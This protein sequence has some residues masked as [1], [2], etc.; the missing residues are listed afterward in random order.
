MKAYSVGATGRSPLQVFSDLGCFKNI[1]CLSAER[2]VLVHK[3]ISNLGFSDIGC[4]A[5]IRCLTVMNSVWETKLVL[6]S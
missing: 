4:L 2:A 1:R 6:H 5:D 3:R